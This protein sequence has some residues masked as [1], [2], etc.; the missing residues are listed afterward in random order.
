MSIPQQLVQKLWNYSNI[1]ALL[2]PFQGSTRF[3]IRDPG[4]RRY[5]PCP[6]LFSFA[7]LGLRRWGSHSTVA[8]TATVQTEGRKQVLANAQCAVYWL[9]KGITIA[10]KVLP[11]GTACIYNEA[12]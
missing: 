8:K 11:N 5:A 9:L 7:P 6:G 3:G 12:Q 1:C 10:K 2:S 4:R